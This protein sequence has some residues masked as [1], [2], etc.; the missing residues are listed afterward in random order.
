[1]T[2][3]VPILWSL[4]LGH[5]VIWK[6]DT[7]IL[8]ELAAFIFSLRSAYR[9]RIYPPG[10]HSVTTLQATVWWYLLLL[11]IFLLDDT[12][13]LITE[14]SIFVVIQ[15]IFWSSGKKEG[16]KF[17]ECDTVSMACSSQCAEGL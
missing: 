4:G 2:L 16:S 12:D 3:N 8:W 7:K 15:N 6:V 9:S 11:D 1:M 10:L 17:V 13:T 5:Y 14:L